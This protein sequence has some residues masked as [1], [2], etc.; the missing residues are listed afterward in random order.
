[1]D[2]T[3]LA[4]CNEPHNDIEEIVYNN[5]FEDCYERINN[6]SLSFNAMNY[7]HCTIQTPIECGYFLTMIWSL[8]EIKF[9]TFDDV[10]NL[11]SSRK[12][13]KSP[14]IMKN[15]EFYITQ[16]DLSLSFDNYEYND[17]ID[18][19]HKYVLPRN[20]V[21][22]DHTQFFTRDSYKLYEDEEDEENCGTLEKTEYIHFRYI[23]LG[24]YYVA[25][26]YTDG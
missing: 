17:D 3:I 20:C 21:K 16:G 9:T 23:K 5:H 14:D 19:R 12:I 24:A 6:G 15:D 4:T 8:N 10:I 18:T 13:T 2:Y 25:M 1:M 22:L 26:Y 11:K 7:I